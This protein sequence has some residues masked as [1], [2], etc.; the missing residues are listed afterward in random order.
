M[1]VSETSIIGYNDPVIRSLGLGARIAQ[2]RLNSVGVRQERQTLVQSTSPVDSRSIPLAIAPEISENS[3]TPRH[4]LGTNARVLL[5]SVY[6]PYARDHED[7]SRAI[8]PMELYHN[9]VTRTQ[10]PFSLRMFHRSWGIMLIQANISAPTTLLDFPTLDRFIQE[11]SEKNYDIIGITSIYPNLEKVRRMCDLIRKHQPNA[12]IVVG[13]HLANLPTLEQRIDAD[14]V[15]RGE[16]IR[17]FREYLGMDPNLPV[18]HPRILSGLGARSMGVP[19]SERRG[20]VAATVIP[21]V[22]CPL[23]CNFCSTSAMFGGKG[24]FVDFQKTGDELFTVM[25]DLEKSLGV[26]SFFM[27][28]ENFLLHRKRALRLLELMEQHDKAW[29]LYVFSSANV[30]KSYTIDQLVRLGISWVWMGLEG[31]QSKYA[32]LSG[33]D[34]LTLVRTLQNNGIRVLGSTIIGMEE[35]TPDNLDAAIDYA[36]SHDTEFHQF[37]LYTPLPGTELWKTMAAENRLTDPDSRE[38]ADSHGQLRFN[39]HHPNLPAGTETQW[40]VKAFDRDFFAN[41]PSVLRVARTTLAGWKTHHNHA[42]PRVRRRFAREGRELPTTYASALWA[43][44]QYYTKDRKDPRMVSKLDAL[45]REVYAAFGLKARLVAPIGGRYVLRKL[46][47]ED[48]RLNAGWTYEPPTFYEQTNQ[49]PHVD[50]N[51][52]SNRS[53]L[54]LIR[55]AAAV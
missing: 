45:L 40:L 8:N 1:S 35:H 15:V 14:H 24:K 33:A 11:I 18:K 2:P 13:G 52:A 10:G 41:G 38:F 51:A 27:M 36:V 4:P 44:K 47:E 12:T 21:S 31:K 32:K 43:A 6:G 55:P 25:C 20:D 39:Y 53:S 54:P 22:G 16:G 46:R 50:A 19:M 49:R 9:Q 29:A 7:G 5:T 28:D 30:L 26:W 23:G 34:T 3:Q 37:M 17:W 48:A 42:D